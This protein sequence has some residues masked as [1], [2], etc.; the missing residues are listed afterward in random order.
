MN[1]LFIDLMITMS[2]PFPPK[3]SIHWLTSPYSYDDAVSEYEAN[4]HLL[5]LTAQPDTVSDDLAGSPPE[6]SMF[7]EGETQPVDP[8]SGEP[9]HWI[10]VRFV[11]EYNQPLN[12]L[13]GQ[14]TDA[15]GKQ[16]PIRVSSL[17][18]YKRDIAA[19]PVTIKFDNQ[20]WF[21]CVENRKPNFSDE[22]PVQN[23]LDENPLGERATP[24]KRLNATAGD[25]VDLEP[26]QQLAPRHQAGQADEIILEAD[27]SYLVRVQGFNYINLRIGVFFDGTS[28]NTYSALWGK[29]QL[30]AYAPQWSIKYRQA[31]Q[32]VAEQNDNQSVLPKDLPN[33]CFIPPLHEA[34]VWPWNRQAFS[35]SAANEPTNVQKIHDLYFDHFADTQHF[36]SSMDYFHKVYITGIGTGNDKVIA[37][38]DESVFPGQALGTGDYGVVAKVQT[39]IQEIEDSI[40]RDVAENINIAQ[41]PLLDGIKNIVFDVFGFSRGAAAARHFVNIISDGKQSPLAQKVQSALEEN[42]LL[43]A[44]GFNWQKPY[45]QAG[46]VGI[47]DTVAS[48]VD[49]LDFDF[50]TQNRD[51]GDVRLWLDPNYVDTAVHLTAKETS[52]YRENFSLNRLNLARSSGANFIELALPGAHSDIGGGYHGRGAQTDNDYLLPLF[53]NITIARTTRRLGEDLSF[54]V[55]ANKAFLA[56]KMERRKQREAAN[57]WPLHDPEKYF[58]VVTGQRNLGKQIEVF[59]ELKLIRVVEGDLSRLYLRLMFGL[60]KYYGVKFDPLMGDAWEDDTKNYFHVQENIG[61]LD[62]GNLAR[63]VLDFALQGVIH[64]TLTSHQFHLDLMRN[65]L[66][67]HSTSNAIGMGPNQIEGRS[68]YARKRLPCHPGE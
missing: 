26:N 38:A 27:H 10:E 15:E 2:Y 17:P 54:E 44:T 33:E 48:V 7:W 57:F 53:E 67:H 24:I 14:L 23:W 66:I 12:H 37:P 25:F 47:F 51:N 3:N 65:N 55:E 42:Q 58:T 41:V 45:W 6:R 50:S 36:L 49:I 60:A 59:A 52:E 22:D 35:G 29:A 32:Q 19:G 63:E 16:Y 46:F 39:A 4:G 11:D 18:L 30:D 34:F 5:N 21:D 43:L 20:S 1:G 40:N 31:C 61:D 68:Q 62:F 64:P 9:V 8:V 56:K 28:N 13:F